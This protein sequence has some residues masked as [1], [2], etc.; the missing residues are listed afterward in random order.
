LPICQGESVTLTANSSDP[1][2]SYQWR[3]NGTDIIN[4]NQSTLTIAEDGEFSVVVTSSTGCAITSTP[5]RVNVISIIRPTI[6]VQGQVFTSSSPTGNQWLLNGNPIPGATGQTYNADQAG[7]FAVRVTSNGCSAVSDPVVLTAIEEVAKPF[8]L[9]LYPNPVHTSVKVIYSEPSKAAVEM[10]I[11]DVAG[12]VVQ[13][14]SVQKRGLTIEQE[15]D[16]KA[17]ASGIYFLQINSSEGRIVRPF[18]KE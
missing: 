9:S 13:T 3:R 2:V 15:I 17:L 7:I 16:L 1:N 4:A 18:V 5:I 11:T 10:L 14:I 6:S 8:G 12:K